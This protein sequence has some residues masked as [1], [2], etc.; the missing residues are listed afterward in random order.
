M[1]NVIDDGIKNCDAETGYLPETQEYT[2]FAEFLMSTAS[3]YK[4]R[5]RDIL[6]RGDFLTVHEQLVRVLGIYVGLL[7]GHLKHVN[8]LKQMGARFLFDYCTIGPDRSAGSGKFEKWLR[9]K[10]QST[11]RELALGEVILSDEF[12]DKTAGEVIEEHPILNECSQLLFLC[13]FVTNPL[14]LLFR[15][16]EIEFKLIALVAE[17]K[18]QEPAVLKSFDCLFAAWKLLLIGAQVPDPQKIFDFVE[19]WK[20]LDFIP[21]EFLAAYKVPRLVLKALLTEAMR[22]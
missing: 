21:N 2:L 3:P 19:V 9:R 12:M 20:K 17:G 10:S 14:D 18:G 6:A 8:V 7:A 11:V 5:S 16:R 13:H 4:L 1:R 15:I 22:E